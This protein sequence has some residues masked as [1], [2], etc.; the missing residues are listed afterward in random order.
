MQTFNTCQTFIAFHSL[1]AMCDYKR[2]TCI[3]NHLELVDVVLF[4]SRHMY[5]GLGSLASGVAMF[6]VAKF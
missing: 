1:S 5:S 3:L 4:S 6:P 2:G